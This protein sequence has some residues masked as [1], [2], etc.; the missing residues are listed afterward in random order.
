MFPTVEVRWF[1]AE[2]VP[3]AVADWFERCEGEPEEQPRRVDYYLHLSAEPGQAGSPTA[4]RLGYPPY[5]PGPGLGVK[6]RQG[7]LEIKG[8][9][10]AYGVVRFHQRV[11]G[12]VEAWRK[13]SF[14]LAEGWS[15]P[16]DL[17]APAWVAVEK[18]RAL[19]RYR[20]TGDGEVVT[21]AAGEI[22]DQACHLELTRTGV[23]GTIW[24]SL[25]LEAFGAESRL[26]ESLRR[27]A[28]HLF[29]AGD[30]PR[31]DAA[32]SYGYPGWL[33]VIAQRGDGTGSVRL[34]DQR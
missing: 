29:A 15:D 9:Q 19:R 4:D 28:E 26:Q 17:A 1:G 23:A 24:W 12:Q 30:P 31:L 8:R 14:A 27:V 16:V 10:H 34:G 2:A 7:R 32:D 18:V 33:E 3:A 11:A 5:V 21:M 20:V 6:L 25:G 13:W 22:A